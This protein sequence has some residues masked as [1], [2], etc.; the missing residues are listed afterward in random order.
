MSTVPEPRDPGSHGLDGE[1]LARA[2]DY[3]GRYVDEGKLA[4]WQLVVARGGA[5]V[6]HQCRGMADVEAGTPVRPDTIWRLH[7]MTKPVTSVAAM[8]LYEAGA[9]TLDDPV[10]RWLPAF[11]SPRVYQYGPPT[12]P[13]PCRRRSRS[14]SGTCSPTPRG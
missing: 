4:G 5:V 13:G 14:G 1:R 12:P 6:W 7:S 3:L 9:F 8:M 11:G 2:G 10:D